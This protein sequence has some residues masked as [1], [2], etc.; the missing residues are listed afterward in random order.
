MA[1]STAPAPA[2]GTDAAHTLRG[3]IGIPGVVFLVV[4]A[5]AP[6]TVVAGALPVMLAIANGPGSTPASG[7]PASP[8]RSG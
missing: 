7:T 4:A 5:A 1:D 6:L 3:H 8:P 2:H